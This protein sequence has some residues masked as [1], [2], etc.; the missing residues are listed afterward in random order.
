VDSQIICLISI[1]VCYFRVIKTHKA[2]QKQCPLR[3]TALKMPEPI[4]AIFCH[5]SIDEVAPPGEKQ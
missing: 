1:A 4:C 2:G 5:T 3:L